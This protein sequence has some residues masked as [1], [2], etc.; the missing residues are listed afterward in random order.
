[1]MSDEQR[2]FIVEAPVDATGAYIVPAETEEE[3]KQK[4]ADWDGSKP[5]E[6]LY[7]VE[8]SLSTDVSE[9]RAKAND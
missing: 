2:W 5:I 6:F 7:Y 8:E 9:M 3:A 4:L 1:M